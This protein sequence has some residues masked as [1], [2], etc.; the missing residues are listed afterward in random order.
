MSEPEAKEQASLARSTVFMT[1]G[2][3]ISRVTGVVRLAILAATLGVAETRFTD[4]YNLPNTRGA[5][6][7]RDESCSVSRRG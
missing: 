5:P 7:H 3:V 1:G 4:T 2:T 6:C